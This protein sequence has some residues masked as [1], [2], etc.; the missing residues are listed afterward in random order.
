M[1]SP[2]LRTLAPPLRYL[3]VSA[4]GLPDLLRSS[5]LRQADRRR[6]AS[7]LTDVIDSELLRQLLEKRIRLRRSLPSKLPRGSHLPAFFGLDKADIGSEGHDA[8]PPTNWLCSLGRAPAWRASV[9][10]SASRR[11]CERLGCARLRWSRSCARPSTGSSSTPTR[12]R[13][14]PIELACPERSDVHRSVPTRGAAAARTPRARA[15]GR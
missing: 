5:P 8:V 6:L 4:R 2:L 9:C 7:Y 11:R 1:P 12:L 13:R 3:L 10:T 14:R 15:P